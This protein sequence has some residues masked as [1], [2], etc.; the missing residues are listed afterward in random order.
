MRV[1]FV[2][3]RGMV[4]SVVR[5][6]IGE[7]G[8]WSDV[9]WAFASTS[10][11]GEPG[12][13]GAPLVDA[14]DLDVLRSADVVLTCQGS[15]YTLDVHGPL[16]NAGWQGIWLDASSALRLQPS[17]LLVLDPMNGAALE[18]GLARGV[19]DFCGPN[20]TV[21]LMLM[22]IGALYRQGWV[23]W[24]HASTYQAASGAGARQM[25]ELVSQW[26][27]AARGKGESALA[28][29]DAVTSILRSPELPQAAL[30]GPLAGNVLPWI[31]VAM[32]DGSTREE[33]KAHVES[34]KILGLAEPVPVDGVCVRVGAL[35]CHSQAL[36]IGLTQDVP[37]DEIEQVLS[38]SHA[39]LDLVPNEREATLSRLTPVAVTGSLQVPV[40]RLRRY[41]TPHPV[42]G[43]FTLG[44]QLLW[45]AAEP[46][47]RWL[48]RLRELR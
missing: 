41:R 26:R 15:A 2:G 37:L 6:R 31:D 8:D 45:G 33:H 13:D 28:M 24:V 30:G 32:P 46:L 22:A 23:S 14:H 29:G 20:C 16:R 36:A 35:R 43:C 10:S 3:W 9:D 27:A 11:V 34:Q 17:S 38:E 47:V 40:G 44:D 18:A 48:S 39:W 19:R 4:G 25:T 21:S 7:T 5:Q 1:V 42:L 12:P